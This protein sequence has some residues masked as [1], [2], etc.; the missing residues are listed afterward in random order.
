MLNLV[1]IRTKYELFFFSDTLIDEY[2]GSA[3]NQNS[4]KKP[5]FFLSFKIVLEYKFFK[6][7]MFPFYK[8]IF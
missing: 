8:I 3:Y 6:I 4:I 2:C 7:V 5:K 1:S